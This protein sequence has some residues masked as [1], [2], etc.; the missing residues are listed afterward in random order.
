MH[1]LAA[2]RRKFIKTSAAVSAGAV[3]G[4]PWVAK[5]KPIKLRIATL[6]PVGSRWYKSFEETALKVKELTNGEVEIKVFGGGSMGDEPAMIRKA[7]TGQIDA[8]ACTSVGL[9]EVNPQLLMLQMPMLFKDHEDL[10]RT[11]NAMA[12]TFAGL[13][14]K[15]GFK[16]GAWGDVGPIYIFSNQPVRTPSDIKSCKMWVWDADRVSKQVMKVVGANAVPLSVDLVLSS[17]KSGVVD[18][19]TNSPY[20]AIALQWYTEAA[21]VTNLKLAM[22]IGGSVITLDAWNNKLNDSHRAALEQ[23]TAETHEKLLK[24]IR[25]DNKRAIKTLKDKG[26]QVVDPEDILAW[27][28]AAVQVRKDLTGSLFEPALVEQMMKAIESA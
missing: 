3:L 18:A 7:R 28:N 8:V 16:L 20:G 17:L 23:A 12:P 10:D 4:A 15:G 22:G 21:Y 5:A 14:E 19:F 1:R 27:G 11:R 26:L 6:A 9:G 13:L 2:T 24:D 25:K